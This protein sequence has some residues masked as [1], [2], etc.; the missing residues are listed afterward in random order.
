MNKSVTKGKGEGK[1]GKKCDFF[2][3]SA[4][5][6]KGLCKLPWPKTPLSGRFRNTVS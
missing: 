1:I 5:R 4:M 2:N 6:I 3:E